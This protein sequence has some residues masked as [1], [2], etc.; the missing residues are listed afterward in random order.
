MPDLRPGG[1]CYVWV[2]RCESLL[3]TP[4]ELLR[5]ATTRVPPAA[6]DRVARLLAPAFVAFT[7]LA[8]ATGLR[9]YPPIARREAA[10]ALVDIFGAPHAHSH[11]P[12][13][14]LGWFEAAGFAEAWLCN[15]GRRGFGVC[16]RLAGGW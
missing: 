13:E 6:F 15:E 9:A 14:V 5:A 8:D 3:S 1:T 10:L 12:A 16:G 2:Y 7:R 11:S 4:L